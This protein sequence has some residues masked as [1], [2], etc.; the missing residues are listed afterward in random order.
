MNTI[1]QKNNE[2]VSKFIKRSLA[3]KRQTK[4]DYTLLFNNGIELTTENYDAN[5]KDS[6]EY[7]KKSFAEKSI[8]DT[9]ATSDERD[10]HFIVVSDS[11]DE[12]LEKD[13]DSKEG[14]EQIILDTQIIDPLK[15]LLEASSKKVHDEEHMAHI[16]I[17][18]EQKHTL[19]E[20]REKLMERLVHERD[21][22]INNARFQKKQAEIIRDKKVALLETLIHVELNRIARLDADLNELSKNKIYEENQLRSLETSND[23]DK[24]DEYEYQV[25]K[26][27]IEKSIQ[28]YEEYGAYLENKRNEYYKNMEELA[29]DKKT[30]QDICKT[31]CKELLDII[32]TKYG[33]EMDENNKMISRFENIPELITINQS[34]QE[35]NRELARLE[36]N[37]EDIYQ[38]IQEMMQRREDPE[39]VEQEVELLTL[40]V[41][42]PQIPGILKK[43]Q[44]AYKTTTEKIAELEESLEKVQ[45]RYQSNDYFNQKLMIEDREEIALLERGIAIDNETAKLLEAELQRYE[46]Q[47]QLPKLQ[48]HLKRLQRTILSNKKFLTYLVS[49]SEE[50]RA[51]KEQIEN[52]LAQEKNII[53]KIEEIQK[54]GKVSN[55][56]Q[57]KNNLDN[58]HQSIR[59]Q[60]ADK[61]KLEEKDYI[62]L[63]S[64]THDS[65]Q[66]RVLKKQIKQLKEQQQYLGI[67]TVEELKTGIMRDYRNSLHIKETSSENI[68]DG[69]EITYKEAN[70]ELLKSIREHSF[71]L[72]AMQALKEIANAVA[73]KFIPLEEEVKEHIE[74]EDD[75][76]VDTI[77]F[78][79]QD[80][81]NQEQEEEV[82]SV[83]EPKNEFSGIE[84][85][86]EEALEEYVNETPRI[87]IN[88]FHYDEEQKPNKYIMDNNSIID[89]TV[90]NQNIIEP[91]RYY[92]ILDNQTPKPV[93]LEE[94]QDYIDQG[95]EVIS[96]Y[97]DEGGSIGT[98]H[99]SERSR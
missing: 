6:V 59:E 18:Q 61:R 71:K 67:H 12:Q 7:L 65:I 57:I 35:I 75:K 78:K 90:N 38:N 84:S 53:D 1:T 48:T 8:N 91:G 2:S 43:D 72:K 17:L 47:K 41:A 86:L 58:I 87:D 28:A 93:T 69:T 49:N 95:I 79:P 73:T 13:N 44:Q 85:M 4:E 26:E 23:L 22:D 11:E 36:R 74:Y 31:Q 63:E 55:P 10:H 89:Y 34:I 51:T 64:K 83:R 70:R 52:L 46:E 81:Y 14:Q 96:T 25:R 99:I 19:E 92:A 50:Y 15:F 97:E 20:N 76:F 56:R 54:D 42:A 24:M 88:D 37:P 5:S 3:E 68:V 77:E 29:R 62:D 27:Q 30:V 94:A 33:T 82:E 66:I 39:I 32:R 16:T 9:N 40:T 45:T 98:L 80:P 60:L 21:I